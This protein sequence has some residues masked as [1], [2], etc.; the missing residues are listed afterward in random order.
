MKICYYGLSEEKENM[1]ILL[2]KTPYAFRKTDCELYEDY[3][4]YVK[5]LHSNVY[6]MIIVS[7]DGAD[8]MEGVIAAKDANYKIPVVWFSDDNNFGIQAF[9]LDVTYFSKKPMNESNVKQAFERC[10]V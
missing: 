1:L 6:D 7:M 4:A 5:A 10:K 8:G 3:E 9:R 2:M